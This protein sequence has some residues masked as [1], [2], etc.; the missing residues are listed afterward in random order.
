M[1]NP[2]PES[3]YKFQRPTEHP[4]G[5]LAN[6]ELLFSYPERL[7]DIWENKTLCFDIQQITD[8]TIREY[9]IHVARSHPL[10]SD[11]ER[12]AFTWDPEKRREEF[13][14]IWNAV[15]D[16]NIKPQASYP[17][18]CF[19]ANLK[20][21]YMWDR[22]AEGHKGFCLEFTPHFLNLSSNPRKVEYRELP[23]TADEFCR[24]C[25]IRKDETFLTHICTSKSKAY[26]HEQEWRLFQ[27]EGTLDE[28]RPIERGFLVK[29]DPSDLKAIYLGAKLS[30]DNKQQL[31]EH[32]SYPPLKFYE[33]QVSPDSYEMKVIP[34]LGF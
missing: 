28:K 16:R 4:F 12:Y 9:G 23:V 19:S 10:A 30:E 32:L 6:R 27:K 34:L 17:V 2:L 29:Y 26:E 3:F 11:W 24:Q 8:E 21:S 33:M 14:K 22:F 31:K 25:F 15:I 20:G 7:S 1:D 13:S 18:C 5:N